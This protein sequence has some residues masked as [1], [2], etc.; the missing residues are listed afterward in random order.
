MEL[1]CT[2]VIGKQSTH[3]WIEKR[4]GKE[5]GPS[6]DQLS[7]EVPP[8]H[9]T[10]ALISCSSDYVASS[11]LLVP[12]L[13]SKDLN[14]DCAASLCIPTMAAGVDVQMCTKHK[15]ADLINS[16]IYFGCIA[17]S[18]LLTVQRQLMICSC[19]T[20]VISYM[21]RKVSIHND[22]IVTACISEAMHICCS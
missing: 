5:V 13:C 4:L 2:A 3:P 15:M 6:A 22:D 10:S 18:Q 20:A 9:T 16:G 8:T 19:M 17:H 1:C 12:M 21:M 11:L 14:M 7:L